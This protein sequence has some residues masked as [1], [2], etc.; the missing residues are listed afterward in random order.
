MKLSNGNIIHE[1]KFTLGQR[2]L[3][4][5]FNVEGRPIFSVIVQ[6]MHW[7]SPIADGPN[8]PGNWS[9]FVKTEDQKRDFNVDEADLLTE[10]K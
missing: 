8:Y 10:L 7:H 5:Q 6:R 3:Y 4:K 9:Y 2:L 1:P